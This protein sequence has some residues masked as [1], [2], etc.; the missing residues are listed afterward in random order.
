MQY[1]R[2]LTL[3]TLVANLLCNNYAYAQDIVLNQDTSLIQNVAESFLSDQLKN[4]YPKYNVKVTAPDTRLKLPKCD[5][6]TAFIPQA[7]KLIGRTTIGVRCSAPKPWSLFLSANIQVFGTYAIA[8]NSL[9]AGKTFESTDVGLIEGELSQLP[10][11][12]ISDPGQVVGQIAATNIPAGM[13]LRKELLKSIPGVMQG[14]TVRIVVK[15]TGFQ[16]TAEGRALQTAAEGQMAN[17]KLDNGQN[18]TGIARKGGV[19][20]VTN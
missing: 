13:P 6:L 11:S 16:I 7:G 3:S 18:L 4:K 2:Y 1:M 8:T 15:G 17:V 9:T 5:D 20:E 10:Q 19:V 14:Q 12:V